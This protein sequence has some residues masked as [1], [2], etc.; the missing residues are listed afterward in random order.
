ML[1]RRRLVYRN[2]KR[3]DP[4]LVLITLH[5]NKEDSA[6]RYSEII[7]EHLLERHGRPYY[8]RHAVYDRRGQVPALRGAA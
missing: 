6:V 4:L 2:R 8:V 7:R 1:D 5:L 3:L